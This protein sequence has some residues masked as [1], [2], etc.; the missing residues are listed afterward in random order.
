MAKTSR[1]PLESWQ[2]PN[3]QPYIQIQ[4]VSKYYGNYLALDY[5][6]L[7]IYKEE[8]FSLLGPSGCGKSTLLRILAGFEMPSSGK[9]LLDGIDITHL[10]P[11][12]RPVNMMFQSYALFPHMTVE[13]NVAYG[14]KQERLPKDEIHQRVQATLELVQMNRYQRRKPH[15][16]S[17]GQQQRV[18]LARSLVKQPKLLLLDEPM[19]ALDKKLREQTQFEL[20]DLQEEVGVTCMMVTHDQEEAMTMS[21][22][23][24]VMDT[25]RIRQVGS[26]G[27]VY[28]YPNSE[29]VADFIGTINSLE[30]LVEKIG[31]DHVYVDAEEIPSQIF[32]NHSA[33]VTEGTTVKIGIRPE[34]V[35][36]SRTSPKTKH[37]HAHGIIEDIAYFGDLSTYYIMLPSGKVMMASL[38]NLGRMAEHTLSWGD[39]VYLH[40]LPENCIVM[41]S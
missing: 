15:Q 8:F 4:Q 26:P 27:E 30:G 22:R 31:R 2:D 29:Y 20:V 10:P 11:Y 40:W 21:T 37:N 1:K 7:D 3:S 24:G 36:I 9:I 38:P 33:E 28:E 14:L 5:V 41:V 12:E 19:G 13:Q 17:G 25:G 6:S 32:V 23:M 18:A 16:L 34:K 39:E 35:M